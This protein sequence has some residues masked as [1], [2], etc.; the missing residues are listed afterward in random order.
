LISQPTLITSLIE[1]IGRGCR[2]VPVTRMVWE[3]FSCWNRFYWSSRKIELVLNAASLV[4]NLLAASEPW[5][6]PYRYGLA[7]V[8]SLPGTGFYAY[9]CLR[10]ALQNRAHFKN[11]F[12]TVLTRR[13]IPTGLYVCLRVSTRC[14]SNLGCNS[15]IRPVSRS[16]CK[17]EG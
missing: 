3:P 17:R 7:A 5:M 9:E 16:L 15:K 13:S 1:C 4:A 2:L 14:A 6:G 11:W 10:D 8:V 12:P